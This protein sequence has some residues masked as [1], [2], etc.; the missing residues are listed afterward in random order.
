MSLIQRRKNMKVLIA[1][2]D[3]PCSAAAVEQ[4]MERD[5][6]QESELKV[7]TVIEPF[8]YGFMGPTMYPEYAVSVAAAEEEYLNWNTQFVNS[9]VDKLRNA[10][11]CRVEGAVLH[12]TAA[13]SIVAEAKAWNADLL[14]VGSHG[15]RGVQKFFLGS[16]SEKVLRLADCS[17]EV[18]NDKAAFEKANQDAPSDTAVVV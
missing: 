8:T 17:V 15:R 3:S 16:V 4:M 18:I 9:E 7:V 10:L 6:P 2:D 11:K 12:G 13:E 5:W 1:I 14:V